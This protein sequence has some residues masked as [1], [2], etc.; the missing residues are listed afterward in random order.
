MAVSAALLTY[1][2]ASFSPQDFS[3]M[4]ERVSVIKTGILYGCSVTANGTSAVNVSDGWVAIRG[5]LVKI[6]Q[7]SLDFQLPASGTVTRY[8]L[9]TIDLA[10]TAAPAKCEVANSVP[11]DTEDFNYV[12]GKAYF[13]LAELT[14]TTTGITVIDSPVIVD[15]FIEYISTVTMEASGWS[16]NVYSFESTYPS[17]TYDIEI[18]PNGA[19]VTLAQMKAFGKAMIAGNATQNVCKAIGTVPAIDIP[20]IVRARYKHR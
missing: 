6:E 16:N 20:I 8:V 3:I 7:G 4:L 10:N 19:V 2:E 13:S 5:R 14:I 11:S 18:E 12:N 15:P 9:V 17:T 1:P